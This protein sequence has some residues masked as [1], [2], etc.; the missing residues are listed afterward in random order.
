MGKKKK[1]SKKDQLIVDAFLN[2]I[3]DTPL[4]P[5]EASISDEL[6]KGFVKKRK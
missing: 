2:V 6:N 5:P 3:Q 1:F 4:E